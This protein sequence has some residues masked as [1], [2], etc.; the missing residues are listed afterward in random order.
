MG[1][2]RFAG[3]ASWA[4]AASLSARRRLALF[5]IDPANARPVPSADG[6]GGCPSV[7]H[8]QDTYP[9]HMLS[10]ASVRTLE[11]RVQ[12]DAR[13]Q[14]LDVRR[15]RANIILS[16]AQEYDED[17][18]KAVRFENPDHGVPAV[19]DVSCR[20]IRCKMP[21]VDPD[22]GVRH[23]SEPDHALRTYRN[24]D[25]SAPKLGCLGVQL[26]PVFPAA[27]RPECPECL[28]EVGMKV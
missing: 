9:L 5:R 16:G 20:T 7:V 22:T 12:K 1:V 28:L 8:F 15:F 21:N 24:V 3:P 26:C 4:C 27:G 19:F 11:V 25:E 17:S 10:L 2:G 6:R 14:R 23:K 18:W 13:L